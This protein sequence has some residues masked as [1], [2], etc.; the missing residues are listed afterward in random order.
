MTALIGMGLTQRQNYLPSRALGPGS[1]RRTTVISS[2]IL[3]V[4]DVADASFKLCRRHVIQAVPMTHQTS[5]LILASFSLPVPHRNAPRRH[6]AY[7]AEVLVI[8]E[9]LVGFR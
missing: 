5:H 9:S 3:G 2:T 8:K 6:V 7:D 4:H 1:A